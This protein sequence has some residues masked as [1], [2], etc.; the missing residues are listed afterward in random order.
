[1]ILVI[2]AIPNMQTFACT[3]FFAIRGDDAFVGNNEDYYSTTQTKIFVKPPEGKKYGRL[4]FGFYS[5][6]QHYGFGNFNPQGGMNEQGLFFDCFATPPLPVKES[7]NKIEF[8]D[9]PLEILLGECAT[10]EDVVAKFNNYNLGFMKKFQIFI[11]DKTGQSAIIEGDK[12]VRKSGWYQVVTSFYH[13][14]PSLG[15]YPCKRYETALNILENSKGISIEQFKKIL[16][17]TH[18][19]NIKYNSR[20]IETLYSNI[21]DLRKGL[22]YVYY[23]HDFDN[24]III[25]LKNEFIKGKRFY[26]LQ[27]LFDK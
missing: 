19:E 27:S 18:V 5:P 21:Y 7:E 20:I 14:N 3:G 23:R 13:S 12:I 10:V 6:E 15:G 17:K 4:F 16:V 9:H 24:E 26:N 1:M 11:A 8:D 25:N 2:L 22:V